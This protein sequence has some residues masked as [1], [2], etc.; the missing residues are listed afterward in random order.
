MPVHPVLKSCDCYQY[1]QLYMSESQLPSNS[2]P[3]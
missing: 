2:D 3:K 1:K